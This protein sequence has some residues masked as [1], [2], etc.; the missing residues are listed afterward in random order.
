MQ[1]FY[2]KDN[3]RFFEDAICSNKNM[4][5]HGTHGNNSELI[6][7]EGIKRYQ[8]PHAI[9]RLINEY[10]ELGPLIGSSDSLKSLKPTYNN[11]DVVFLTKICSAAVPYAKNI[12]GEQIHILKVIIYDLQD[13]LTNSNLVSKKLSDYKLIMEHGLETGEASKDEIEGIKKTLYTLEHIHDYQSL[14]DEA[15]GVMKKYERLF[16]AENDIG[17]IYAIEDTRLEI[18]DTGFHGFR[19]SPVSLNN[20][21]AKTSFD[22]R[23]TKVYSQ[24]CEICRIKEWERK[25]VFKSQ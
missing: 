15:L 21:V 10:A 17:V 1:E 16:K 3:N 6:E 4:Y 23:N 11:E 19:T 2:Y 9:R 20:I 12:G 7:K 8:H 25:G 22:L 24:K 14:L 5:F 18:E 13:L